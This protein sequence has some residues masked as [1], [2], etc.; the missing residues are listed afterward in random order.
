MAAEVLVYQEKS[1][2][3]RPDVRLP[4]EGVLHRILE[5]RRASD[6]GHHQLFL[7]DRIPTTWIASC[8]HASMFTTISRCNNSS[9][10]KF[11][12]GTF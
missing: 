1:G 12:G 7:P 3:S 4:F 10:S 9:N 5:K 8:S 2:Y 11:I 6:R